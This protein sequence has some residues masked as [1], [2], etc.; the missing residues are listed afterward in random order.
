[1]PTS[2]GEARLRSGYGDH[3][4]SINQKV[5]AWAH[6]HLGQRVGRGECWDLADGALKAAAG[7]SST[8]TGDHDDYV[9]GDSIGVH[10]AA[11]GDIL[12]FRD[13]L[14]VITT[15]TTVTFDDGTGYIE[16]H[17][18]KHQRPHH[19]AVVAAYKPPS[20][21]VVIEQIPG[22]GGLRHEVN[23]SSGDLGTKTTFGQVKDDRGRMRH[24]KIEKRRSVKVSGK[25]WAYRPKAKAQGK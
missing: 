1:M 14:I 2:G 13:H 15:T 6:S 8:T 17:E 19:T 4:T 9:W 5:Y 22:K 12:Q 23:L 7:A 20:S 16:T 24:A 18:E 3:P 25:V 21:V 11:I 10:Q